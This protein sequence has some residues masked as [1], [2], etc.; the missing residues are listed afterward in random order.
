[1]K[2]SWELLFG[3]AAVVGWRGLPQMPKLP[4]PLPRHV[5]VPNDGHTYLEHFSSVGGVKIRDSV[6]RI[7]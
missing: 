7:S 1:M 6:I 4:E 3:K 5:E 2:I